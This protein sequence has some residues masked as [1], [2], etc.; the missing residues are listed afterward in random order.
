MEMMCFR[1]DCANRERCIEVAT[2][3]LLALVGDRY[4][5]GLPECDDCN[6]FKEKEK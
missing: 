2:L 4:L 1:E 3:G 6:L 5:V